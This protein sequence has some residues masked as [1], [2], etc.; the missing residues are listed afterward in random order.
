[1]TRRRRKTSQRQSQQH[2]EFGALYRKHSREVWAL[3]YARFWNADVANDIA[4]EAFL[5]LWKQ[6]QQGE[7]I[8][9]SRAWLLR[10]ARNLSEDYRDSAFSRNGTAPPQLMNGIRSPKPGPLAELERQETIEDVRKEIASLPARYRHIILQ[11]LDDDS[12]YEE[13][14][15]CLDVSPQAVKGLV[16]R[17]RARLRQRLNHHDPGAAP[18]RCRRRKQAT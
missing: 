9:N 1:M 3:A 7:M 17:A 2:A 13:I 12:T 5:R 18:R 11:Q 6:W 8:L 16:A 15:K 10:V 14:A 4:Q